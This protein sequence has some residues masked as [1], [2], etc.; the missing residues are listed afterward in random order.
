MKTNASLD[1]LLE[2]AVHAVRTAGKHALDNRGRRTEI[3]K[4]TPHD[5]KLRLDIE[6]QQKA[7]AAIRA[8]FPT[9]AILGEED[10]STGGSPVSNPEY[11]WIIDPIDGTVNFSHGLRRW[12]CSIAVRQGETMLA[13]AVYKILRSVIY[14]I[15]AMRK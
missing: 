5:V 13:G 14:G 15:Q 1:T 9:H 7:E 3:V 10:E 12:C 11:E 2:C 8:R 4:R 6:C